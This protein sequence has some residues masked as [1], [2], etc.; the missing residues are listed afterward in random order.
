MLE[1]ALTQPQQCSVDPLNNALNWGIPIW[2]TYELQSWLE[3]I[4]ASL[5]N[6]HS[7]KSDS[8]INLTKDFFVTHFKEPYIKFESYYR[9]IRPV[10]LEL[11][12]W[13]TINFDGDPGSCPFDLKRREK[14]EVGFV[15]KEIKENREKYY[16]S[17]ISKGKDMTR[18]PRAT[19]TRSRKTENTGYCEICRIDYRNLTKHLQSDQHLNFVRNDKN[20]ISLDNLISTGASVEAFLKINRSKDVR[21]ECPL[22]SSRDHDLDNGILSADEKPEEKD[23]PNLNEFDIEE[24]KMMQCNGARRNLNLDSSPHNLRVRAKHESGHQLRSKGRPFSE[25]EK[26]EK[27]LVKYVIKKRSKGTYWIEEG[28]SEDEKDVEN[29]V[30]SCEKRPSIERLCDA[31]IEEI[32]T[33]G[34]VEN[35]SMNGEMDPVPVVD[36]KRKENNSNNLFH[37]ENALKD[38]LLESSSKNKVNGYE[39]KED[40]RR[41]SEIVE[42]N[43]TNQ[44]NDVEIKA[45]CDDHDNQ[46]YNNGEQLH[47]QDCEDTN[48]LKNVEKEDKGKSKSTLRRGARTMKGRHRL[49]VE[50][51]L[52]EDNRDYYKVEVLG[53]KLRSNTIPS[54]N[55]VVPPS[56][57][58]V[59]R[60]KKD[61][62]SSSEKNVVVRF[63]RVRK[64]EL[65]L[66][67][68]EAESFMFGEPRRDDDSSESD[69]EQSSN[70]PKDTESD[71]EDPGNS[72]AISSSSPGNIK[73]EI[74]DED[75]QD[76]SGRGRKKRRTQT[77]ALLKDN[78]EYYKFETPGSRL[79][80]QAPLTGINESAQSK[81][82]PVVQQDPSANQE[83]TPTVYPSKPSA[84]IE[85]MHFSFEAIPKSESW[86]QTYQ[87]QDE[88]EEFYYSL[89]E[90]NKPFLLPYEIENFD[91]ILRK[92]IQNGLRKK[93]RGKGSH[94]PINNKTPR[95][96]PRCHASTLA[97][98]STIIRRKEQ[99]LA[100]NLN[101][102][103]E[104]TKP[105]NEITKPDKKSS[106]KSDVDADLNEIAKTIDDVLGKEDYMNDMDSFE[107][108]IAKNPDEADV[109]EAEV[110][111]KGAPDD[112]LE[113]LDNCHDVVTMNGI[114]NSSCASSDCGELGNEFP[115]KRRKK[116]K[117]KTGWPG[118]KMRRKL[119][120]KH[121]HESASNET[122]LT[123]KPDENSE[124]DKS[125]AEETLEEASSHVSYD[126][127]EVIPAEC[128][129]GKESELVQNQPKNNKKRKSR[130]TKSKD[131]KICLDVLQ[132]DSEIKDVEEMASKAIL[133]SAI[134]EKASLK[135]KRAPLSSDH[136]KVKIEVEEP[137][138]EEELLEEMVED[139]D[140]VEISVD[141]GRLTS[142]SEDSEAPLSI[143]EN[144]C[145]QNTVTLKKRLSAGKLKRPRNNTMSSEA[146]LQA[147]LENYQYSSSASSSPKKRQR[148]Q[149]P[150]RQDESQER[151]S[152]RNMPKKKGRVDSKNKR[153]KN[154]QTPSK[155]VFENEN[156]KKRTPPS[157][158]ERRKHKRLKRNDSVSSELA[159]GDM[160]DRVS[161]VSTSDA[162]QR[163]SSIDF[164]PVV[165]VTKI[166]DPAESNRRLRSS[167]SPH[168]SKQ[169]QKK[170]FRR[171]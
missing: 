128:E 165:R 68:D 5:K 60:P 151:S 157:M 132:S 94:L 59:E 87:R 48:S 33:N 114:E 45:N 56:K 123:K 129:I 158:N 154:E 38:C 124:A 66:L 88:G 85:K 23:N 50:E 155:V 12:L 29:E 144:N 82:S 36:C 24:L 102:V 109:V 79:R 84:E 81:D 31:E 162:D 86:Y 63:K 32:A 51:R 3:K 164:Q 137:E 53:S 136:P 58:V 35:V 133:K 62:K 1:R 141:E 166:D 72:M 147:E 103:E 34:G 54:S 55:P 122:N 43:V 25:G 150:Q 16:I 27:S 4:S 2:S 146:S 22:F 71:H 20:F 37:R 28:S 170:R 131:K 106:E 89:S 118:N 100:S 78:T 52:I 73:Q 65:T 121:L 61:D 64:S 167:S 42:N 90:G 98:M 69:G 7:L 93:S 11:Q 97:I 125:I 41:S 117:N 168:S 44:E 107:I 159:N 169:P 108:D 30:I 95:K 76:S 96:S 130:K 163:R 80:F 21:K 75:S 135:K 156:C 74:I 140:D 49:S 111:P 113:L 105:I 26:T 13:P 8:H 160:S 10:F 127:E 145:T 9:D 92:A 91:E 19:A 18:R 119:H 126:E 120:I 6:S 39:R 142:I 110:Q 112:L 161:L 70:L 104:E 115:S 46:E 138:E 149:K 40:R 17:N 116:R 14:K 57:E 99:Q 153:R 47:A 83:E 15:Q 134:V 77:E 67:S 152:E 139:M 171:R 143:N 101:I 148:E